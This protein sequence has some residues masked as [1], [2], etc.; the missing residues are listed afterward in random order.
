MVRETFDDL[1]KNII[2]NLALKK[3]KPAANQVFKHP[4]LKQYL[5]EATERGVSEEFAN[6]SKSDTI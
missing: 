4:E 3:W 5:L 2:K 6:L 1:T